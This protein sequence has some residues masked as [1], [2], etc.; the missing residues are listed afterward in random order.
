MERI[1]IEVDDRLA[2]AWRRASDKK[3]KDIG[4][5]VNISLA[6]ELMGPSAGRTGK[7]VKEYLNFLNDLREEMSAKGLTQEELDEILNDE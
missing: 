5:K 2:R 4:N 7:S 1:V 6:K 3:R